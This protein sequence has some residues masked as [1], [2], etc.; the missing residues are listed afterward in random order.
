MRLGLPILAGALTPTEAIAAYAQGASAVKLFPASLGGPRYLAALRDPLPDMPFVPVGG[1]DAELAGQYLAGGA[2]AVGVG[3]P[4]VR[5][6]AAGGDLAAL[7]ARARSFLAVGRGRRSTPGRAL[8]SDTVLRRG[9]AACP[10]GQIASVIDAAD[11]ALCICTATVFPHAVAFELTPHR[12]GGLSACE[13][14]EN[15]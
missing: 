8:N 9:I 13:G 15:G 11:Q 5:D 3:S 6:A 7:R 1:V 10:T 12:R 2:L 4:L 14:D